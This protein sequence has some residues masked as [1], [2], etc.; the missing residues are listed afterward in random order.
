MTH[1]HK[2]A[3][4]GSECAVTGNSPEVIPGGVTTFESRM[5][6]I[7]ALPLPPRVRAELL[8]T[9][10]KMLGEIIQACDGNGLDIVEARSV[11]GGAVGNL[12]AEF[13]EAAR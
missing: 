10:S 2:C 3:C 1:D 4:G 11:K 13:P 8:R 9:Y 6:E 5:K 7:Q 12:D